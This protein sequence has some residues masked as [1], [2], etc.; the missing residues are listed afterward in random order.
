MTDYNV[1]YK[2]PPVDH[3]FQKGQSGN[4]NGRRKGS[5]SFKKT[6]SKELNSNIILANGEKISK[7][8]A[9]IKQAVN[10]AATGN[11]KSIK[12]V[13]P[14]MIN[15]E[16]D[17]NNEKV[18]KRLKEEFGLSD[19]DLKNYANTGFIYFNSTNI[20][21]EI[22]KNQIL[23]YNIALES[24]RTNCFFAILHSLDN[25]ID[26][27]NNIYRTMTEEYCFWEN[28]EDFF[29]DTEIDEEKQNLLIQKY[30]KEREYTRPS[31]ELYRL[32][33]QFLLFFMDYRKRRYV[34]L[35]EQ[36]TD[37]HFYNKA[38]KEFFSRSSIQKKYKIYVSKH[39][40]YEL[41]EKEEMANFEVLKEKY[42][43]FKHIKEYEKDMF[44]DIR[45]MKLEEFNPVI[46]WYF[47]K[48]KLDS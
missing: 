25:V 11:E 13:M 42:K 3:Q 40:E 35:L 31:F 48:K 47:D 17:K 26:I 46:H 38:E 8:E 30:E 10:N 4:P 2:K 27:A 28:L 15:D 7:G 32:S 33:F 12:I 22:S 5:L 14:Y 18:I 36:N 16:R 29:I 41:S 19:K 20:L 34:E 39:P 1:G 37:L 24:V 45:K 23:D 9:I 6:F 21:N 43:D 44:E